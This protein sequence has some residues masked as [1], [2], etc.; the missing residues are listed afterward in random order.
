MSFA[1]GDRVRQIFRGRTV[2]KERIGTII[3]KAKYRGDWLVKFDDDPSPKPRLVPVYER[4]LI[5]DL[6]GVSFGH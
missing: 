1:R 4:D 6:Q 3:G 5:D 2:V